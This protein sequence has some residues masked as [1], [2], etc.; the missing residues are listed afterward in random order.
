METFLI[1]SNTWKC[2]VMPGCQHM[3]YFI[4]HET[5]KYNQ[6]QTFREKLLPLASYLL[7]YDE[8]THWRQI[9]L[10]FLSSRMNASISVEHR[11]LQKWHCSFWAPS[12]WL[13]DRQPQICGLACWLA[14][15]SVTGVSFSLPRPTA[16]TCD[17]LDRRCCQGLPGIILHGW[18]VHPGWVFGMWYNG[19]CLNDTLNYMKEEVN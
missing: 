1:P 15:T 5:K 9:H 10:I 11:Y 8:F 18:L 6:N 12:G 14:S 13:Y 2:N 17:T 7:F 3:H 4:V 16:A 19:Q